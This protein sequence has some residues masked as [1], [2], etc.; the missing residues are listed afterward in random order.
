VNVAAGT[1]AAVMSVIFLAMAVI[2]SIS[3]VD[4]GLRGEISIQLMGLYTVNSLGIGLASVTVWFINL[5]LPAIIGSLLI[6]N[7]RV[8]N[9]KNERS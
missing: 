6:L 1:I 3:L 9:K 4:F 8:F 5:I 2:P 7:L